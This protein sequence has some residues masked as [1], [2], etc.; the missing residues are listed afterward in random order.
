MAVQ[1]IKPGQAMT[2]GDRPH[3]RTAV[4]RAPAALLATLLLAGPVAFADDAGGP[5][6]DSRAGRRVVV[7]GGDRDFYPYEWLDDAGVPHGFNVDLV[8]ELGEVLGLDVRV[9]LDRWDRIRHGIEVAGRIDI[10]EMYASEARAKVV[11]FAEPFAVVWEQAYVREGGPEVSGLEDLRG[12]R[13]LVH[14]AGYTEQYLRE[15][16]PGMTLIALDSEYLALKELAEGHGDVALVT[17]LVGR[18]VSERPD[19]A[20]LRLSGPPM[21]PRA[22]G[23]VVRKGETALLAEVNRGME[24]LRTTGR[25][26]ALEDKWLGVLEK[27]GPVAAFV[28][29]NLTWLLMIVSILLAAGLAGTLVLSRK[30]SRQ[31]RALRA[32]LDERRRAEAALAQSREHFQ[33]AFHRSPTLLA[34]TSLEDG[35]Y[36]DVNPAFEA[37]TGY[38]RDEVIGRTS[39]DLGLWAEP[40][41]H[42]AMCGRLRAGGEVRGLEVR[43]RTKSGHEVEGLLGADLVVL[44]GET[45]ILS[46]VT[47]ISE[48]K[49]WE[50]ALS[51]AEERWKFAL[52]GA[53]DG[54]WDWDV[55]SSRCTV[56]RRYKEILG[57]PDDAFDVDPIPWGQRVHPADRDRLVEDLQAHVSG[58]TPFLRSEV[59]VACRDGSYRWGALR[60]RVMAREADG[61]PR[62]VLGTLTDVT[63]LR[64]A[65]EERASLEDQLRQ[66]QKLEVVGQLAGGI[67]HDFN[68]QLMVIRGY[69]DLLQNQGLDGRAQAL[70]AE[71]IKTCERAAALTGRLLAFGRKQVR[72]LSVFSPNQVLAEMS[73]S[74]AMMTGETIALSIE[75]A[76]NVGNVRADRAQIEQVIANIVVNARDAMPGGGQLVIRTRNIVLGEAFAHRN[77][78]AHV[79]P[80]VL[81]SFQDT[82]VG[83]DA[84]IAARIFEPFFTTKREGLGTGLGLSIV[85]GIM[86]QSGGHVTVDSEPGR[87]ATF[88]VYL[89]RVDSATAEERVETDTSSDRVHNATILFVEDD[90]SLF[91]LLRDILDASGYRVLAAPLPE[92][93]LALAEAHEGEIDLLVTDVV[94]PGLSGPV[95]AERL[96]ARHP[97]VRVLFISGYPKD[98]LERQT[99]LPPGVR[100]LSKPFSP[101]DL[102]ATVRKVLEAPAAPVDKPCST[103]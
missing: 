59:R 33:V 100:L 26:K 80:H 37:L 34:I 51:E 85:Y 38:R 79:G 9:E 97:G 18:L 11:D 75:A 41:D 83:M 49:R 90:P 63:D 50:Q 6:P 77:V 40:A 72:S 88:K 24:I 3:V 92:Q 93:A 101:R 52:E 5:A 58:R 60:G 102:L 7:F 78:G 54:V 8:R 86:K 45:C 32:E 89:P 42:D 69:C 81:M 96:Q 95:V 91:S 61:R 4:R 35:R 21:L 84:A 20:G 12:M 46:S 66:S 10:S 53:G 48:R 56:S 67:A 98:V 13:V 55:P 2:R 65:E 87:G 76:P 47:D 1:V 31:A 62:R 23:L 15:H 19:L 64:R 25:L 22:Y 44:Q 103:S 28:T 70:L 99:V 68:N 36:V 16:E 94:M 82:G 17:Q 14:R 30:V 29:R 73:G 43:I 71:V 39:R 27:P 57:Y 74:L